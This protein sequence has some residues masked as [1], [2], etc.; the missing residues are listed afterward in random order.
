[1]RHAPTRIGFLHRTFLE[2][3]AAAHLIRLAAD[4]VAAIVEQRAV[5]PL[6]RE[7]V[8]G[9]FHGTKRPREVEALVARVR[10]LKDE[11]RLDERLA[12][13]SL[14]AEI[15]FGEVACPPRL[16]QDLAQET[17]SVVETGSRMSHREA[18][19][20]HVLRGLTSTRVG[21]LVRD[22]IRGWFPCWYRWRASVF[23][24]IGRWPADPTVTACLWRALHDEEPEVRKAAG[25]ALARVGTGDNSLGGRVVTLARTAEDPLTRAAALA[26]WDQGWPHLGTL[27]A[28]A[29]EARRSASPEVRLEGIRRR[30]GRG[31]HGPDDREELFSLAA[32]GTDVERHWSRDI[33]DLLIR[34][35]PGDLSVR[36]CCLGILR[37][38][39]P[40]PYQGDEETA[41][42]TPLVGFL[43]TQR[44]QP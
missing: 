4:E 24:E 2:Y 32:R 1:M 39:E 27:D 21:D 23:E 44:S 40:I 8:L 41:W 15:T 19:L 28:V 29:D 36:D 9:V 12:L 25:L 3:L 33:P 35:W 38:P 30:I 13:E 18:L 22:Q 42:R 7:V 43:R 26:A 5:D 31:H 37:R 14:L 17:F 34:G 6:W 11:A 16:A 20:G 10:R